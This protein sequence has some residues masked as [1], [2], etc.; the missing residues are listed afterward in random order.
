M[1]RVLLALLLLLL[2]T[3]LFA[4]QNSI[5]YMPLVYS[6]RFTDRVTYSITQQA[7]VVLTEA[8]T[9]TYTAPCHTLR[10]TLAAAIA[11]GPQSYTVIFAAHLVTNINIT[12]G[13]ALTGS[14]P[15]LDSPATDAAI[16]AAVAS[17]WSTVSGC[18]TNP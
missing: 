11:R 16:L 6:Q 14:G 18:F 7:P 10:A 3:P 2:A 13:G 8:A 4:Q 5:T 1:K 15:T 12:S 17:L 9:G